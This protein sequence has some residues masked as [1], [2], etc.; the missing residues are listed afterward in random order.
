MT[1]Q[2]IETSYFDTGV[3]AV[4]DRFATWRESIDV[5][6]EVNPYD[7]QTRDRYFARVNSF[8]LDDIAINHC[9][10]GAQT[11]TR[12]AARIARDGL[13]HYQ[14]HVYLSGSIDMVCGGR[15]VSAKVGDFVNLDHAETF[16]SRTTDYEILNV[17]IPRRRLAPLLH[18]PDSTHGAVF[19]SQTSSGRLLRDYVIALHKAAGDITVAQA[20]NAA[21]ALVQ[22]A[23][24]A[25]NGVDLKSGE[26]PASTD[27]ALMLKAQVFIK[28]NLHK[29]ELG[30]SFIASSLGLSRARLYRV[31]AP[32][33]GIAEYIREM[34]L[35]RA[36]TDLISPR[37]IHKQVAQIAYEWGFKDPAHFSRLFR[38]RFGGNPSEVREAGANAAANQAGSSELPFGDT[39][40]AFWIANLS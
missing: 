38:Q 8:L 23:A 31:F 2:P 12:D 6:F 21:E 20:P 28:E 24:L 7:E 29:H 9:Q 36:F 30:P 10:L 37:L 4:S 35:R 34:R 15:E 11:Y 32:C 17:F 1:V 19:D 33:G 25:L 40:Y 26:P 3:L 18:S 16:S 39:K 14:L 5:L 27:H 13:D 22:L